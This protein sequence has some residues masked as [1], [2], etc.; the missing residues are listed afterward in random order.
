VFPHIERYDRYTTHEL[1]EMLFIHPAIHQL[2]TFCIEVQHGPADAA[3]HG[4]GRE[5]RQPCIK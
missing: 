1:T 4:N 3:G 5:S 2:A